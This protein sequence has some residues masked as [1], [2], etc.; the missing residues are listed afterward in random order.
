MTGS[1]E[2]I[3]DA[4]SNVILLLLGERN[5]MYKKVN[6]GIALKWNGRSFLK[7]P[8]FINSIIYVLVVL[9]FGAI[10][11][12]YSFVFG[13]NKLLSENDR[14]LNDVFRIYKE[15]YDNFWS[16]Y[17]PAFNNVDFFNTASRF[18]K[19]QSVDEL[20]DPF[21]IKDLSKLLT[22]SV[23]QDK[24]IEWI[25]LYRKI[26]S[27]AGYVFYPGKIGIERVNDFPY[28]KFLKKKNSLRQIY[29][30]KKMS[31]NNQ[32]KMVYAIAGGGYIL[33]EDT[34][35][36]SLVV[37]YNLAPI[38]QLIN[39]RAVYAETQIL[40]LYGDGSII[41][42]SKGYGYGETYDINFF[43]NDDGVIQDWFGE[44]VYF[45]TI[46]SRQMD[47]I[48]LYIVKWNDLFIAANR[49]TPI[50]LIIVAI[51]TLLTIFLYSIAGRSIMRRINIISR[52]LDKIG[53]YNLSYKI[54]LEDTNDEFGAITRAINRMT[55][56]LNEIIQK[57]YVYQLKQKSAELAEL[58]ARINPHFLYNTLEV[59]RGKLYE[60]GD[61]ETSEMLVILSTIFRNFIRGKPFITI[62]EELAF[63][64]MYLELFKIRY[65]DS[66]DVIFDVDS[67]I[68]NYGVIRNL[69]QPLI[70]NYFVHGFKP[71]IANNYIVITGKILD[72]RYIEI[73][74]SDNGKGITLDRLK[75]I[76]TELSRNTY[77]DAH[78]CYG[79]KNL[80]DRILLFY[81]KD[82]GLIISPNS[83][84]GVTVK[85]I[86]RK[87]TCEEHETQMKQ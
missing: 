32:E 70:E 72:D 51:F 11:S 30:S 66:V 9:L 1:I 52:G 58:Q 17:M 57:L 31:I 67:S 7:T 27:E 82:C 73:A 36:D 25:M 5:T 20:N 59:I 47:F 12:Y 23:Q 42:D 37:G 26:D 60:K 75:Q 24:D 22:W 18:Y 55:V 77:T 49:Y 74:V 38:Y 8:Y 78:Q 33:N 19:A 28:L 46:K 83:G 21:L 4:D 2:G 6:Q 13:R 61:I 29:G 84:E 16:I 65:A 63:C 87:M 76:E 40:M 34:P 15:K 39:S 43:E 3:K 48:A 56:H 53:S 62:R 68:L 81:G 35:N 71:N 10:V 69:I 85:V 79:L 44:K 14:V 54:P 80:K 64:N 86:I 41:F 50:I 45:K